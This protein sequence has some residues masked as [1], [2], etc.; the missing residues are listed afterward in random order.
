MK[1]FNRWFAAPVVF[2]ALVVFSG[3]FAQTEPAPG[4]EQIGEAQEAIGEG[5]SVTAPCFGSTCCFGNRGNNICRDLQ[6]DKLNCG[7]CG[8]VCGTAACYDVCLAGV[9]EIRPC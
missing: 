2:G 6:N 3:C 4:D 1:C 8:H 9:C 7:A 5:C